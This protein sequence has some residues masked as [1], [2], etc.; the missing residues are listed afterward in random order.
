MKLSPQRSTYILI[1][2]ILASLP[3]TATAA[4]EATTD[5]VGFITTTVTGGS[6]NAPVISLISPTLTRP[7]EWQGAITGLSGN[8]IT[9]TGTPW[10]AN[11]FN[12]AN[13]EYYVEVFSA[14]K[15]GA[16]FDISA[17]TTSTITTL[18]SLGSSAV[19]GD[20]IRIR[21]HVTI[22]DFLGANNSAGLLAGNDISVADE[23]SVY[24]GGNPVTYWYYDGTLGGNAGWVD[25]GF[26]PAGN[27]IIG[28]NEGVVIK[29][30]ASGNKSIVFSGAVKTG[31][32]LVPIVNGLNVIGTVSAKGLT[33]DTSGL[34]TGNP[35][36]TGGNDISVADEL[37]VY[38]GNNQATYWYYDGTL[39]G[40][41][42][43][44]DLGF[45]ASGQTA[46][47]AGSSI[48]VKRKGG[49]FN[50]ELPAPSSF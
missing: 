38:S 6:A 3:L 14:T 34:L 8:T 9:V 46:I 25:L 35:H 29:R 10:S 1:A 31:N 41:P 30:K 13:G 33:L 27:Q 24:S 36:L 17:T 26:Q 11:Q 12:G 49:P 37:T 42:G 32:T 40:S 4:T 48:V 20:S 5:P 43:W 18:T 50:W 19:L 21:K 7:V 22:A 28:P 47:A 23:V 44:V 45:A 39:G 2:G 15:P 16:I